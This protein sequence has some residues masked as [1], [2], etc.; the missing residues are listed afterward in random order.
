[1]KKQTQRKEQSRLKVAL[2]KANNT[3]F[4]VRDNGERR[5]IPL[6]DASRALVRG[7]ADEVALA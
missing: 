7:W 2:D 5:R 6:D 4:I 1:M 3:A